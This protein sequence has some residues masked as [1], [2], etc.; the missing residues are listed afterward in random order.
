MAV[1]AGVKVVWQRNEVAA[2]ISARGPIAADLMRRGHNVRNQALMNMR[3][4]GVGKKVGTGTLARSIVVEL[5]TRAALIVVRV[6]SRLPYAIYVHEGHGVIR[7]V[8]A[9]A[10]RWPATA[11]GESR[12]PARR[13]YKGGQTERYIFSKYVR[14]VAGK[15]FLREA[16]SA[17]LD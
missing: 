3:T 6:G 1:S 11:S 15:P 13:R 5:A 14:P 17:A 9:K 12:R 16:I 4:M 7:P 10:L 2:L 8:R